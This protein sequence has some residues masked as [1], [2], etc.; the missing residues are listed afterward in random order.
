MKCFTCSKYLNAKTT[1]SERKDFN[2]E[3][4]LPKKRTILKEVP[5]SPDETFQLRFTSFNGPANDLSAIHIFGHDMPA[6]K[7]PLDDPAPPL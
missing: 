1:L 2:K 5:W 3:R 7:K 6:C 4:E